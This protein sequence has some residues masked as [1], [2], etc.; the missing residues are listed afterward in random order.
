MA[1]R[2]GLAPTGPPVRLGPTAPAPTG[3]HAGAEA[4]IA[5]ADA[6][7]TGHWIGDYV[8][9]SA[10]HSE[11]KALASVVKRLAGKGRG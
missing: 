2:T 8:K 6:F 3:D 10:A 1:A 7:S 4:R 11:V 9:G 5:H